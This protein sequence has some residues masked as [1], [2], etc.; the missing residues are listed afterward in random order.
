QLAAEFGQEALFPVHP[1]TEKMIETFDLAPD[2]IRLV[3]PLD[4]L[5]L[6]QLEQHA[7]L[8]LTD[9][10]GLQDEACILR[11]PC[12]TLRENTERPSTLQVGGNVL[13]GTDAKRIVRAGRVMFARRREWPN[14]YG[15][16][17]SGD[18][19]LDALVDVGAV[20]VP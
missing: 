12:V 10:G 18:A 11:V 15:N 7:S 3:P 6:L 13:A 20:T 14:P 2:G 1:R 19:I 4:Y 9:S 8:I 17:R 5:E 16:G